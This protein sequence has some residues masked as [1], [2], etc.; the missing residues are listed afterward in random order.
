MIMGFIT[1]VGLSACRKVYVGISQWACVRIIHVGDVNNLCQYFGLGLF[2]AGLKLRL[3]GRTTLIAAYTY[4]LF[5]RMDKCVPVDWK[6]LVTDDVQS[7]HIRCHPLQDGD[8]LSMLVSNFKEQHAKAVILINTQD[9][10]S[11]AP[12]FLKG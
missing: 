8:E 9:N 10:Y 4:A 6:I 12:Q 2:Y 11:I 5:P 3:K 7:Q 1:T